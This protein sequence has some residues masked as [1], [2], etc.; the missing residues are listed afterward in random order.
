MI[1]KDG[2]TF[3]KSTRAN[4]KYMVKVGSRY[5]HFGDKRYQHYKDQIGLYS[6]LNHLDKD[7]KRLYYARHGF[8]AVKGTPKYFSHKYLW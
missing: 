3:E 6:H 1:V 4:K 7:R 5:V 2:Y 8:Q